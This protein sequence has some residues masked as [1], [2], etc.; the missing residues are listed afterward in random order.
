MLMDIV[1]ALS[2]LVVLVV[3]VLFVT[4]TMLWVTGG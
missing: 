4:A 3:L 2:A 1:T